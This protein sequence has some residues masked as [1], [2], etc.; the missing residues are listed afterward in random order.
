MSVTSIL[1]QIA[2]TLQNAHDI[3]LVYPD[4]SFDN[5]MFARESDGTIK[6]LLIDWEFAGLNPT[7]QS[8]GYKHL[9]CSINVSFKV[10]CTYYFEQFVKISRARYRQVDYKIT[11]RDCLESLFYVLMFV[12]AK[13][14]LPWSHSTIIRTVYG[15][16]QSAMLSEFR[17]ALVRIDPSYR[18]LLVDYR[19]LLF[20]VG[21]AINEITVDAVKQLLQKPMQVMKDEEIV[22]VKE[23]QNPTPWMLNEFDLTKI[24]QPVAIQATEEEEPEGQEELEEQEDNMTE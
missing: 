12:A 4:V 22:I 3:G 14:H 17:H 13:H 5:I 15:D 7:V 24:L 18:K 8:G 9:F 11:L 10:T 23:L 19:D 20:G 21:F 6:G 1:Y 16:K 2:T